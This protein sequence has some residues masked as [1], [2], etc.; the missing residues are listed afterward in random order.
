M[1][2][3]QNRAH[4]PDWFTTTLTYS[5]V[6]VG[7]NLHGLDYWATQGSGKT[8]FERSGGHIDQVLSLICHSFR[9]FNNTGSIT[10]FQRDI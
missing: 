7:E 3:E 9:L 4:P 10:I 5:R 8:P 2:T 6:E 1:P